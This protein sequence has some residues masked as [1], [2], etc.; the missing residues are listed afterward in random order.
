MKNFAIASITA[1]TLAIGLGAATAAEPGEDAYF[2]ERGNLDASL[3]QRG[4]SPD[5]NGWPQYGYGRD[6]QRSSLGYAPAYEDDFED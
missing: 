3:A 4:P 2:H 5:Q 6:Y 1:A